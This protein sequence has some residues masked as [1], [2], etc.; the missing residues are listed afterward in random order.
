MIFTVLN[1]KI[2][3]IY[4]ITDAFLNVLLDT[5]KLVE[6]ACLALSKTVTNAPITK[7]ARSA[8]CLKSYKAVHAKRIA[9]KASL[10]MQASAKSALFSAMS[11]K[12][13]ANVTSAKKEKSFLLMINVLMNVLQDQ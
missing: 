9:L 11:A 8:L 1:A 2:T 10:A 5:P 6:N 4:S 3:S 12:M 13:K 7:T